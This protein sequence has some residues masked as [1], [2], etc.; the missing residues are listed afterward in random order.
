MQR[1]SGVSSRPGVGTGIDRAGV[2]PH[3][4]I[5]SIFWNGIVHG[6]LRPQKRDQRDEIVVREVRERHERRD[7]ETIR[8]NRVSQDARELRVGVA[9]D[10]CLA[11]RRDVPRVDGAERQV[12]SARG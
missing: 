9:P 6:A 8:V 11:I 1:S 12:G 10:A 2:H 4:Q 5:Q 7:R 3:E